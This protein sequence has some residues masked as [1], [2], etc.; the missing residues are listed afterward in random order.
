[1]L[2]LVARIVGGG[3]E[4][5]APFVWTLL[6]LSESGHVRSFCGAALVSDRWLVTAAHCVDPHAA[7]L[8]TA[9][10]LTHPRRLASPRPF[11]LYADVTRH[12]IAMLRLSDTE[13][14]VHPL[15][16]PETSDLP[17]EA[18]VAGWGVGSDGLLHSAQVPVYTA[19]NCQA[20]WGDRFD[21]PQHVCAGSNTSD[22]CYGDSGGP[23]YAG[24][25]L[26]G[27][28]SYGAAG[29]NATDESSGCASDIP[30]VFTLVAAY[31]EWIQTYVS[32]G[33]IQEVHCACATDQSDGIPVLSTNCSTGA[34]WCYVAGGLKC[35]HSTASTQYPSAA[36]RSCDSVEQP[37]PD[38]TPPTPV[39]VLMAML[40]VAAVAC[41]TCVRARPLEPQSVR[42]SA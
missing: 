21:A 17:R 5:V 13:T 12:D 26:Y 22:A 18:M 38:A 37:A 32:A 3:P 42:S 27:I 9:A 33:G 15:E 16:L 25:V 34:D 28:V 35:L 30:T 11:P 24:N 41:V 6:D 40:A 4:S 29:T 14:H 23:L 8:W 31:R 2:S 36:W 1:M 7:T 10:G 39:F 19:T 20:V